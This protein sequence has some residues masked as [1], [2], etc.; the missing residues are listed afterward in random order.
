MNGQLQKI[1][2]LDDQV[3]KLQQKGNYEDCLIKLEKAL[4]LK[5]S[6]FGTSSSEYTKTCLQISNI[7][8]ILAISLVKAEQFN[9]ALELL[10]KSEALCENNDYGKSMTYNNIACKLRSALT[11]LEKSLEIEQT[12]PYHSSKADTHLNICAVLSQMNKHDIALHHAQCAIMIVQSNLLKAFLPKREKMV[13][14]DAQ[15][16]MNYEIEK[17]FKDRVTVLAIAYHN[18]GVEQEFLKLYHES[19]ESYRQGKEFAERY[20]GPQDG[21]TQSLTNQYYKAKREIDKKMEYNEAKIKRREVINHER[22]RIF[23]ANS[24]QTRGSINGSFN[25]TQSRPTSKKLGRLSSN[26][27]NSMVNMEGTQHV[28]SMTQF[29]KHQ[30]QPRV[31]SS[32][33]F[34]RRMRSPEYNQQMETGFYMQNQ[35]GNQIM[36]HFPMPKDN[37][38]FN[39]GDSYYLPNDEESQLNVYRQQNERA[40]M[41]SNNGNPQQMSGQG[42]AINMN[43]GGGHPR[44]NF[45]EHR[46]SAK[47]VPFLNY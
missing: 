28:S 16:N 7:C 32:H 42:I 27:D 20:L 44:M 34:R 13:E 18:L 26:Q 22:Q 38:N 10:K 39:Q 40:Y 19:L 5:Q 35:N 30:S 6:N 14:T 21:I 8:N 24:S 9:R 23:T 46:G 25:A 41:T 45:E 11:Y 36:N 3:L 1:Q 2:Q 43:G 4:V 37:Q 17:N 47:E 12:L 31:Q 15:A 33:H 29:L